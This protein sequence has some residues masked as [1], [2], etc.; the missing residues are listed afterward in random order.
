MNNSNTYIVNIL[1]FCIE[2]KRNKTKYKYKQNI[3]TIHAKIT[4][5]RYPFLSK[6]VIKFFLIAFSVFDHP[7]ALKLSGPVDLKFGIPTFSRHAH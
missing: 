2:M 5:K 7:D 6:T 1:K 4:I 3:M